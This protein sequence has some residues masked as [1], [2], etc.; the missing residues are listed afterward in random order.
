MSDYYMSEGPDYADDT[1]QI[2]LVGAVEATTGNKNSAFKGFGR[3]IST[4]TYQWIIVVGAVLAL[5]GLGRGLRSDIK[6][7]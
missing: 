1:D 3:N 5:W 4:P 7:G 6:I 2:G